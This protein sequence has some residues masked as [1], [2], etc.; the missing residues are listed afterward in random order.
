MVGKTHHACALE[1][2][3]VG[4]LIKGMAGSGKTSLMMG[5]LERAKHEGLEA[6]L[7]ADDQVLLNSR[8]QHLEAKVPET[9]AG[10]IEIRGYGITPHPNKQ[11]TVINLVV[12]LLEDEK[13]ERMPEQRFYDFQFIKLPMLQVPQR[14]ENQAVRIIFAW[15]IENAG[16]HVA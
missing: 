1:I 12:E 4:I 3:Q 14:H 5:L 13:I 11:T 7:I 6:F 16:L 2:S 10:L 9:I 15:L 8:S